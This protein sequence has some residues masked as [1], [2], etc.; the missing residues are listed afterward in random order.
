VY[1]WNDKYKGSKRCST[2]H[3][4]EE[5]IKAGFLV[6]LNK[7]MENRS[8]MIEDCRLVQATLCDTSAID[9]ELATQRRE[10]YMVSELAR[11]EIAQTAKV[12]GAQDHSNSYLER[13]QQVNELI[14][15]LEADKVKRL[16]KAKA[17]ERFVREV[18]S[19]PLVLEAFDERL[20]LAVVDQVTIGREDSMAYHFRNGLA[21]TA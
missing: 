6:T 10:L 16:T 12:A 8:G 14:V 2:P 19:R 20:W 9:A 3:V 4:T 11:K 15:A 18:E 5:Q 1:Q 17:L 21:V 7:L 13:Y